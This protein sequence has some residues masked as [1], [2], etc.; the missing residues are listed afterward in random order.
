[1]HNAE[2]AD[3]IH[4]LEVQAALLILRHHYGALNALNELVGTTEKLQSL[5]RA[6]AP[7]WNENYHAAVRSLIAEAN[8]ART[9]NASNA[10]R[11]TDGQGQKTTHD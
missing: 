6:G 3:K 10:E 7:H 11:I 8:Y 2:I 5:D 1:M 9:I 4:T